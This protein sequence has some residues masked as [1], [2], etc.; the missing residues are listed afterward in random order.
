MNALAKLG[1]SLMNRVRYSA[2]P[3]PAPEPINATPRPMTGFF[4]G[5][6]AEQKKAALSYKGPEHHGSD[7]FLAKTA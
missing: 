4:A 3:L 6:S 5:L 1:H 2:K 7:E